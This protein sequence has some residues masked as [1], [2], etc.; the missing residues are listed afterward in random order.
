V[1]EVG[2]T[3]S[4]FLSLLSLY[5]IVGSAFFVP[6]TRW[7]DRLTMSLLKIAMAGCICFASGLFFCQPSSADKIPGVKHPDLEK[8]LTDRLLQ[9]MPVRMFFWTLGGVALMFLASWYIEQYY[10]PLMWRNQPH[11]IGMLLNLLA[12]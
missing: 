3:L 10:V 2:K 4:F 1:F 6:G 5:P 9:T 7:E 11:E 8:P 12:R